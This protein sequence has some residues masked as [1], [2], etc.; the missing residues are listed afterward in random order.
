MSSK[1]SIKHRSM[2]YIVVPP[3]FF[4]CSQKTLIM[5]ALTMCDSF[6]YAGCVFLEVSGWGAFL[7]L[8]RCNIILLDMQDVVA[9]VS[10]CTSIGPYASHTN[11]IHRNHYSSCDGSPEV[12]ASGTCLQFTS[13]HTAT[14]DIMHCDTIPKSTV[15]T[16]KLTQNMRPIA[17]IIY[18]IIYH[19]YAGCIYKNIQHIHS[20]LPRTNT[21]HMAPSLECCNTCCG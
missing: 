18:T 19:L 4:H 3:C 21:W 15:N 13:N 5:S 8:H 20:N 10:I 16:G 9:S 6:W 17:Q 14:Q 1:C 7:H 11:I 12:N 2:E